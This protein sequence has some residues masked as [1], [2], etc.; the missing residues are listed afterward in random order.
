MDQ[1]LE[2]QAEILSTA[3]E[4]PASER[5]AY[6]N[7]ACAGDPEL[8]REIESLLEADEGAEQSFLERGQPVGEILAALRGQMLEGARLGCY[9]LEGKVGEG[10]LGVVYRA[11]DTR[12]GARVALKVQPADVELRG[13]FEREAALA[14]EVEHAG[15]ARVFD[16]GEADGFFY[17][18]T[19]LVEGETLRARLN[20]GPVPLAETL[21]I[22]RALAAALAAIHARGIVHRDIKPENVMAPERGGVK[23]I[24]FGLAKREAAPTADS[25]G[26]AIAGTLGYL[27]PEQVRGETATSR[28]D[29]F[30][31]GVVLYELLSGRRAFVGATGLET[32]AAILRDEPAALPSHV[33]AQLGELVKRCLRK[34][35][36]KRPG[37]EEVVATLEEVKGGTLGRQRAL[38]WMGV[39]A[40][41]AMAGALWWGRPREIRQLYL[42]PFDGAT[43]VN[44]QL[45]TVSW[46]GQRVA[47][48]AVA[49]PEEGRKIFVAAYGGEGIEQVTF[50][51]ED[52]AE[53]S[54]SPRGDRVAFR[55]TRVPAGIYVVATNGGGE[56]KLLVAGGRRPRFS[57]DGEWIAYET[58]SWQGS[59]DAERKDGA[60][61][62]RIAA[63][64][65]QPQRVAADLGIVSSP[66]WSADSRELHLLRRGSGHAEV[67]RYPFGGKPRQIRNVGLAARLQA[68]TTAGEMVVYD[69]G[70]L[71]KFGSDGEPVWRT[72]PQDYLDS[73]SMSGDGRVVT[74]SLRRRSELWSVPT[75]GG[76]PSALVH[77]ESV[78]YAFPWMDQAGERLLYQ[79]IRENDVRQE[80]LDLRTRVP[81]VPGEKRA[82][83]TADGKLLA[84]EVTV[85][86][87]IGDD[88]LTPGLADGRRT[89]LFR[90]APILEHPTL[91]LY[92]ASVSP[93]QRWVAFTGESKGTP[94]RV[95]VAPFRGKEAVPVGEWTTAAACD[96]PRWDRAG[97]LLCLDG[98]KIVRRKWDAG[99]R[100]AGPPETVV[101][102]ARTSPSPA[103]LQPGWFRLAVSRDRIVFPL[104]TSTGRLYRA[105]EIS[106]GFVSRSGVL[107]LITTSGVSL[108]KKALMIFGLL[109]TSGQAA[110]VYDLANDF[111]NASNPNGV[112]SFTQGTTNLT[113]FAIPGGCCSDSIQAALAN[114]LWSVLAP[115]TSLNDR[116]VMKTTAN[117]AGT[118]S[119]TNN[120]WLSGDVIVHSTNPGNGVD[121]FIRWTAPQAG[122][123]NYNGGV[124]YA[125]STVVRSSDFFVSLNGG[126]A[127]HTG[128]VA[129]AQN[130][131]NIQTFNGGLSVNAGDVLAIR[132]AP[133]A[134]QNLGS[135]AGVNLTVSL[136]PTSSVPEPTTLGLASGALLLLALGVRRR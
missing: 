25:S 64:G 92:L 127:L 26:S 74:G 52:D 44:P 28:S 93:D 4:L 107:S 27:A 106:S 90:G 132:L 129:G 113:K 68:M 71:T 134:G 37:A 73:Y 103:L 18:A 135:L 46:D 65:G 119:Y 133:T 86:D 78:D 102:F 50:G 51:Q 42:R 30:A 88:P 75:K 136:E 121:I 5:Q 97:G 100:Q 59:P 31:F 23:L 63:T 41:V 15:V 11:R 29:V 84:E 2:R 67:W 101:A 57:P 98:L 109:A 118:G 120:D 14:R 99:R 95:F 33:P 8:Q 22:A 130:R 48:A 19:E 76:M 125:H 116:D 77:S 69:N 122:T 114:G 82:M 6:L 104:G 1:R 87:A 10:G 43:Q 12:N 111:S 60:A 83:L 89:I 110:I 40:L 56:P 58:G 96:Y 7:Q 108:M 13:R 124:W 24:D 49:R 9:E 81:S 70:M 61:I 55:S 126:S 32:A 62:Y 66:I 115:G 123:I 79:V 112:W 38:R 35:G 117:G 16:A 53:P 131:S 20:R 34:Q 45:P 36:A 105:Q 91:H 39:A 47:Y 85:W 94:P 3:L 80:L 128:T 21:G 54:L 17:V 72:N